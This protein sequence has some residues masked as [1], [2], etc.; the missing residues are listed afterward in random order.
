M[1]YQFERV[2][3]SKKKSFRSDG[4]RGLTMDNEAAVPTP[5]YLQVLTDSTDGGLL[6]VP[7]LLYPGK[8]DVAS[9]EYEMPSVEKDSNDQMVV[10]TSSIISGFDNI[11]QSLEIEQHG[12]G[13]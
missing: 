7:I 8:L 12:I 11:L 10:S 9:S 1:K 3:G 2:A 13:C 4:K 6:T 5:C